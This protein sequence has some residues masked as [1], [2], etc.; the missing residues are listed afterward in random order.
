MRRGNIADGSR[1]NSVHAVKSQMTAA[2]DVIGAPR[3][4]SLTLNSHAKI[5][6]PSS[7]QRTSSP[8]P[9]IQPR[10]TPS[11]LGITGRLRAVHSIK[12]SERLSP[13]A[14]RCYVSC[15]RSSRILLLLAPIALAL[16]A[17]CGSSPSAA[18]GGALS[19]QVSGNHLVNQNGATI[20]LIGF[21]HQG[22]EYT[23]L[24]NS[25][26]S[27][28]DPN[29]LTTTPANMKAWGAAVNIARIT[30]NEDCWLNINGVAR[31]GAAYQNDIVGFVSNLHASGMYAELDLHWSNAGTSL[32]NAKQ[33]MADSDHSI[34]FWQSVAT[35]FKSDP[36]VI[37][38]LYNEPRG[39]TWACWNTGGSTCVFGFQI[40]GMARDDRR[41]SRRRRIRLAPSG[42]RR[43]PRLVQ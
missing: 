21:G 43:W 14:M 15:F 7:P 25:T 35:R 34:A 33:V 18:T 42:R 30:L 26:S 4:I 6:N 16:I 31:G 1:W 22:S 11:R 29:T 24:T 27:F 39:I 36:A 5:R 41:H 38:D 8:S 23:C 19:I 20:H 37:F 9:R 40:A 32:A 10:R 13:L 28:D 17:G 3:F 2:L 12:K